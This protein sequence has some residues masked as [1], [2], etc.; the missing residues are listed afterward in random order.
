MTTVSDHDRSPDMNTIATLEFWRNRRVFLTGHT[1]FKG[2]WLSLWLQELGAQLVGYSLA[3]PTEP[4]LWTGANV[5]N[6]MVSMLGDILDLAHLQTSL[7][8]HKPEVVLHLAAQSIVRRSFADP[9]DTFATNVIGTVNVLEA[10]RHCPSV[11]SVVIVTSDKC[12][13]NEESLRPYKESD[14]LGGFDPYSSSKACAE[15][16]TAAYRRSFFSGVKARGI[17]SARAGNVIGGGDWTEDQLV[18]DIIRG[19]LTGTEILIRNP[20]A[21]RPWQHVMEPLAGYLLLAEK[22][23]YSPARYSESWNFGPEESDAVTVADLLQRFCAAWGPGVPWRQNSGAQVHEAQFLRI[24]CSKAKTELDWCPQ[25]NLNRALE[26]TAQWYK[27]FA[28]GDDLR[29]VTLEQIRCYQKSLATAAVSA[30]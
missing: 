11:R 23:F 27:A 19:V 1:G 8:H 9:V 24:D 17:A 18:P 16:V 5:G 13:E 30:Q 12:Y 28:C 15:L 3:P 2:S 20:H 22:L 29:A 10:V 25:W 21:I 6:G 26:M 14:R 4:N 7:S